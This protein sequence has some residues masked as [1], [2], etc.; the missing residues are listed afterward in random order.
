MFIPSVVGY[1]WI[2][3]GYTQ[4]QVGL[5][6]EAQLHVVQTTNNSVL[7]HPAIKV[8]PVCPD[9]RAGNP[10]LGPCYSIAPFICC[11]KKKSFDNNYR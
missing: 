3:S 11:S 5:F 4:S 6:L 1:P 2:F 8:C 7:S 9:I 10:L